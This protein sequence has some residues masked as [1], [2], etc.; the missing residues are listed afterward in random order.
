MFFVHRKF[1]L[2]KP[3]NTKLHGAAN[4]ILTIKNTLFSM[5]YGKVEVVFH[6]FIVFKCVWGNLR[7]LTDLILFSA[8]V[9]VT[10]HPVEVPLTFKQLRICGARRYF[11]SAHSKSLI[12]VT[13][14]QFSST[15]S[16]RFAALPQPAHDPHLY[17]YTEAILSQ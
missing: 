5:A 4:L 2:G 8:K 17:T 1:I 11:Y 14:P 10:E 3:G 6:I 9:F 16:S 12:F 7:F 15:E 13:L